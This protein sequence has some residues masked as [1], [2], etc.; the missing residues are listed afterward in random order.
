[1][2]N[3]SLDYVVLTSANL[4]KAAW[5]TYQKQK[6]QFMIRSY[7]L[8]VLFLPPR[9][10]DSQSFKL[11]SFTDENH[12]NSHLSMQHTSLSFPLPYQWPPTTYNIK[13]DEPWIWDKEYQ[14]LDAFGATYCS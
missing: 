10:T 1:V 5:G 2:A 8:G 3:Q 12:D 6:T 11:T 4:S 14:E 9:S 13:T 7:E